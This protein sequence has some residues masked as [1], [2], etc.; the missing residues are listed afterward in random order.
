[1]RRFNQLLFLGNGAVSVEQ[2]HA[3]H[4]RLAEGLT[5]NCGLQ[6]TPCK[7]PLYIKGQ[8]DLV[9]VVKDIAAALLGVE[10]EIGKSLP[11]PNYEFEKEGGE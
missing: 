10:I 1:M 5:I 9:D 3:L 6:Q 4:Q 7:D 8:S 11:Y 2:M